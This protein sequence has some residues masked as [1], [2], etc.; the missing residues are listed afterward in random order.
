MAKSVTKPEIATQTL[1]DFLKGQQGGLGAEGLSTNAL[2]PPRLKLIQALSPEVETGAKPGDFYNN[3][4]EANYGPVVSIIPCWLSEVYFLFAPRV[5]GST[6]GLLARAMDAVH[7]EPPDTEFD[8]VINKQGK[9][10]KWRTAKTVSASGLDRWGTF[11]PDDPKSPPAAT[12]TINCLTLLP[13][14][15]E[16]GP[17]VLSFLRSSL[18]I[19]KK[20]AGNLKLSRVPSFGRIF[21]LSSLKVDGQSGPYYEPRVKALGFVGDVAVYDTAREYYEMAKTRGI[22]V[23]ISAEAHEGGNGGTADSDKY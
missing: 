5:P 17:S 7:W 18:K 1:P 2:T 3:I 13:D 15:A 21:Q 4:T 9:H 20:F 19:G 22:E 8:V 16:S 14:D 10:I 11:D 12:H 23:D 6:G